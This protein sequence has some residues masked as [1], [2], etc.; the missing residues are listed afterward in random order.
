MNDDVL[1]L[2]QV[3]RNDLVKARDAVTDKVTWDRVASVDNEPGH[4]VVVRFVGGDKIVGDAAD[5]VWVRRLR[6]VGR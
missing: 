1:S 4:P 2:Y 6:L 5:L 3:K